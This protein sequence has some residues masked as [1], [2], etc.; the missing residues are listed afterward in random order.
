MWAALDNKGFLHCGYHC[1]QRLLCAPLK[2]MS[3]LPAITLFK[4]VKVSSFLLLVCRVS[5]L[6]SAL[7]PNPKVR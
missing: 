4:S 6:L 2:S 3:K 5:F 1:G 7:L